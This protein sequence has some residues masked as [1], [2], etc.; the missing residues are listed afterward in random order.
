MISLEDDAGNVIDTAVT[1]DRDLNGDQQIDPETEAGWYVFEGLSSGSFVVGEEDRTGW[2]QTFPQRQVAQTAYDL[3]LAR[4]FRATEND[5]RNW[6]GRDERWFFG[7]NG[8][9]FITPVGDLFQWDGSPR[10]AL[11]GTLIASLN[12]DY[13]NYPE[14]IHSAVTP[15]KY[16]VDLIQ[17]VSGIDFGNVEDLDL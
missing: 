14:R 1:P 16:R 10:T 11:N 15:G 9:Y 3:D 17:R 8:W 6:G 13:W 4:N 12:S 5:F 7:N 2:T